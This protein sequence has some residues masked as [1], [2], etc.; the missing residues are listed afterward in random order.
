[1]ERIGFLAVLLL[2]LSLSIAGAQSNDTLD[3]VLAEEQLTYGSAAY[4]AATATA[5]AEDDTA[6][7]QVPQILEQ[8]GGGLA[9]KT[10][11]DPIDLGEY[12]FL[13][14]QT[15]EL[16]GGMMYRIMPGP[17]YA[18][19]ELAFRGVIPSPAFPGASITGLEAVR[20]LEQVLTL[21]EVRE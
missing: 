5:L 16:P 14:M 4:L 10:A 15:F 3:R 6:P 20:I 8:K 21:K 2:A 18:V 12:S 9:G 17:R 19:R 1:M 11:S 7:D 13:L